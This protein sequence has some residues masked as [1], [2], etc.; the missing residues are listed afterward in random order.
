M[1]SRNLSN[2]SDKTLQDGLLLMSSKQSVIISVMHN[3]ARPSWA[4]QSLELQ[5]LPP[6]TIYHEITISMW[7][8]QISQ[9][10]IW[11]CQNHSHLQAQ[12]MSTIP[13]SPSRVSLRCKIEKGLRVV[14]VIPQMNQFFWRVLVAL[15]V[16][17]CHHFSLQRRKFFP[18]WLSS[19]PWST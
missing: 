16:L 15:I 10:L 17:N 8:D 7:C 9:E 2:I 14:H 3:S 19:A 13:R 1:V 4:K 5:M 6:V 11:E 12:L 18:Q